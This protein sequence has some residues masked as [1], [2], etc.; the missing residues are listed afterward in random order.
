MERAEHPLFLQPHLF[1]SLCSASSL[2]YREIDA[3]IKESFS[4]GELQCIEDSN[5]EI[6]FAPDVKFGYIIRI[7][8]DIAL[9]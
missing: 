7:I 9:L 6:T 2:F 8:F 4:V 5:Y 3:R 1:V